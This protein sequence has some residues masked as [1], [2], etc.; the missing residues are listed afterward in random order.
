M[1]ADSTISW[2]ESE[3]NETSVSERQVVKTRTEFGIE[4]FRIKLGKLF[5]NFAANYKAQIVITCYQ[6]DFLFLY[7][8]KRSY[9]FC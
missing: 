9:V 5:H 7:F 2:L 3:M 4:P 1:V 8:A 6:T